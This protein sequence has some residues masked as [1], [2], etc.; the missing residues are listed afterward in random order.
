MAGR[1]FSMVDVTDYAERQVMQSGAA[2]PVGVSCP[3][4]SGFPDT[5]HSHGV[6]L[7]L[8]ARW[9]PTTR[10][11]RDMNDPLRVRFGGP[12]A[13]HADGLR[14]ALESRG[15]TPGSAALQLQVAAQLSRWLQASGLGLGDL[16]D[17]A[18][19]GEFFAQRRVRGLRCTSRRRR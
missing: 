6:T 2:P 15:Y 11:D 18:R 14:A 10:G 4:G 1:T 13:A 12:P 9:F 3:A 7:R 8:S 19:V 5:P 17:A 16:A